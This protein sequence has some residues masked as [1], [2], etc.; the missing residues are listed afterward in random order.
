MK[1]YGKLY[2]KLWDKY[3]EMPQTTHDWD[4]MEKKIAELE[5]GKQKWISVNDRLPENISHVL[6]FS[7]VSVK[8]GY[9][10]YINNDW[11]YLTNQENFW[12]SKQPHIEITHWMPLPEPPNQ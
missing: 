1:Y 8:T 12:I 9:A 3:I 11:L 10:Y 4:A 6:I 7:N 5:E 2:G